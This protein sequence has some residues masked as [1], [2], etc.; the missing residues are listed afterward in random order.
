MGHDFIVNEKAEEVLF[1]VHLNGKVLDFDIDS[2]FPEI[3]QRGYIK[4]PIPSVN[5]MCGGPILDPNTMKALGMI[6]AL[7]LVNMQSL[8]GTDQLAETLKAL[9][10]TTTYISSQY[11]KELIQMVEGGE[12]LDQL[13]GSHF[14]EE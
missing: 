11:I 4:T 3:V 13:G 7:V 2:Q 1:P 12:S 6:E 14:P 9:D 5:G 8:S 10:Q